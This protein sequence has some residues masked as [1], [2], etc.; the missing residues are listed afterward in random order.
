MPSVEWEDLG[1][2]IQA[3]GCPATFRFLFY[4]NLQYVLPSTLSFSIS[5]VRKCSLLSLVRNC[6]LSLTYLTLFSLA[7]LYPLLSPSLLS[8]LRGERKY[9]VNISVLKSIKGAENE[10]L[11]NRMKLSSKSGSRYVKC[12]VPDLKL[13]S[14][15]TNIFWTNHTLQKIRPCN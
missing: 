2:F 14:W 5:S 9:K 1:G 13:Q 8:F 6:H 3:A 12:I 10:T 11:K 7:L 15:Q 4:S